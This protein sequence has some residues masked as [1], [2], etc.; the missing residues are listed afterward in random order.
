MVQLQ[1][2]VAVLLLEV[3]LQLLRAVAVPCPCNSLCR[4]LL[5]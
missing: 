5:W 3:L 2:P 4:A 1:E